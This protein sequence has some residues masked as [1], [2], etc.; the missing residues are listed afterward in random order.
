MIVV[1]ELAVAQLKVF[2][3]KRTR[4]LPRLKRGGHGR[5]PA[6]R[7]HVRLAIPAAVGV[8]NHPKRV[9]LAAHRSRLAR[10][11]SIRTR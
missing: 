4:V 2:A 3:D 8:V 9:D 6:F 10:A 5:V 1:G 7:Q 11:T